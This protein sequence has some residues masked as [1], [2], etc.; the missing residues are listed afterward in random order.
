MSM[1]DLNIPTPRKE[2]NMSFQYSK[3]FYDISRF[4]LLC[5]LHLGPILGPSLDE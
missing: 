4:Y 2:E 3:L 1:K 5:Y